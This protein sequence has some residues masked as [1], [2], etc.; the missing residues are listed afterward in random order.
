M[1]TE[2]ERQ[3]ARDKKLEEAVEEIKELRNIIE[4]LVEKLNEPKKGK[5]A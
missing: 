5:K 3:I 4:Q 2:R 1:A